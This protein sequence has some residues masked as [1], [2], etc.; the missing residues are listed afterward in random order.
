MARHHPVGGIRFVC[1]LIVCFLCSSRSLGQTA[2]APTGKPPPTNAGNQP[3]TLPTGSVPNVN[4]TAVCRVTDD[5]EKD[6]AAIGDDIVVTVDDLKPLLKAAA[7]Q[8]QRVVLFINSQPVRGLIPKAANTDRNTL[9]FNLRRHEDTPES[10]NLWASLVSTPV[11]GDVRP[12]AVSVGLENALPQP[13]ISRDY[14]ANGSNLKLVVM[15]TWKFWTCLTLFAGVVIL[16]GLFAFR[17]ESNMIRDSDARIAGPGPKPFSIGRTQMAWWFLIVVASWS[18]LWIA[19][20]DYNTLTASVLGLI[21]ISAATSVSAAVID[22]SQDAAP[23][24][25]GAPARLTDEQIRAANQAIRDLDDQLQDL[26]TQLRDLRAAKPPDVNAIQAV[27][28]QITP[29]E[30]QRTSQINALITGGCIHPSEGFW[31]DIL[32]DEHGVSFHRFQ[33]IVWT[34]FLTVIFLKEVYL[35]L[36]MPEFSATLL[37]LM[38]ISSGTYLGFKLK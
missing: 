11:P 9:Q 12:I 5:Q 27:E 21:G 15:S 35:N 20:D 38:G 22:S 34:V 26:R 6:S 17:Q 3:V 4:V 30:Q 16:F 13:I 8:H 31:R 10:R 36:T 24:A 7:D 37:G 2:A 1:S 33:V 29:L 25:A 28:A 23:P 14:I 32:S 18:L 19:T